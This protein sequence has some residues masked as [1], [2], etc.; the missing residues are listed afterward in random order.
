MQRSQTGKGGQVFRPPIRNSVWVITIALLLA[1]TACNEMVEGADL[2]KWDKLVV[3]SAV[4]M[5]KRADGA[6]VWFEPICRSSTESGDDSPVKSDADGISLKVL[7]LGSMKKSGN[8]KDNSIQPGDYLANGRLEDD[9]VGSGL[10]DLSFDCVDRLPDGSPTVCGTGLSAD[11]LNIDSVDFYDYMEGTNG[12]DVGVLFLLDMSGSMQG[13]VYPNAPYQ[14]KED[15]F[16]NI[17]QKLPEG[18]MF[19]KNGTDPK[20]VRFAAL[21]NVIK[22]NINPSDNVVV[23]A[24][25]ESAF[26]VVCDSE[27]MPS[28]IQ[29][30]PDALMNECYGINRSLIVGQEQGSLEPSELTKLQGKERGRTPLWYA[31]NRVHYFMKTQGQTFRHIVVIGDGPDTCSASSELNQCSGECVQYKTEFEEFRDNLM[32]NDGVP[33]PWEDR[34]PVHFVQLGAKG[35]PERDP[36]QQEV[37]CL[38]GGQH[39]FINAHEIPYDKL[40]DIVESTLRNLMYTVRG[41]WQ[42]NLEYTALSKYDDPPSGWLYA[43]DGQGMVKPGADSLLVSQQEV[44]NFAY[45]QAGTVLDGRISVRKPCDP[46]DNDCYKVDV[47]GCQ[48]DMD[49]SGALARLCDKQSSKCVECFNDDECDEGGRCNSTTRECVYSCRVPVSWCDDESL[50]CRRGFEYET[51]GSASTCGDEKAKVLVLVKTEGLPEEYKE[52]ILGDIPTLCCGGRCMPP[53]PPGIPSD[54]RYPPNSGKVCFQWDDVAGWQREIPEDPTST[55]VYYAQLNA[56]AGPNCT[57]GKLQEHLKYNVGAFNFDDH[58]TCSG[59]SLNCYQPPG[60]EIMCAPPCDYDEKCIGGQ[61]I[62]E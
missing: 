46:N 15:T 21:Q 10:F 59:S 44:F 62:P 56:G 36:R 11:E 2:V 27:S 51:N 17:N 31:L 33:V 47:T 32:T 43:L 41:Y 12:D 39:V 14:Y 7:F 54:F 9:Q 35:Y 37:A 55:W 28:A 19:Q 57:W 38:T 3:L 30:D 24:F 18:Y 1:T 52:V 42:F 20:G 49:C 29:D 58:W 53:D 50:T 6:G 45:G 8:D 40:Q 26:K 23:V 60:S 5:V 48:S 4:P 34:I 13:L 25:N 61:C 16:T 22:N